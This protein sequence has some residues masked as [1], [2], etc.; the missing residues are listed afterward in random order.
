MCEGLGGR[1]QLQQEQSA[2]VEGDKLG[3]VAAGPCFPAAMNTRLP[4][5]PTSDP[6]ICHMGSHSRAH[7]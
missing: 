2:C 1:T 4:Q 6:Q 3:K 5:A 7:E